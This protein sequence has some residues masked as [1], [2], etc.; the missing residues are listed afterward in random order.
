MKP[1]RRI[2]SKQSAYLQYDKGY[3]HSHDEWE[4]YHKEIISELLEAC[5]KA[6]KE[7]RYHP[8]NSN[9]EDDA[10]TDVAYNLCKQAIS[11]AE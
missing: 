3:N 4:K 6:M 10:L 2:L 9:L 5:K 8:G 11:K 7:L 1:T